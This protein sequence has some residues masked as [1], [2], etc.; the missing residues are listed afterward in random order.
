[1]LNSI[2]ATI[3]S[4]VNNYFL[5]DNNLPLNYSFSVDRF[6]VS[7]NLFGI[8]TPILILFTFLL[9]YKFLK[10]RSAN[11]NEFVEDYPKEDSKTLVST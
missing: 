11:N 3:I 4:N 9:I 10:I 7:N 6:I 8:A 5:V 1:M 2:I